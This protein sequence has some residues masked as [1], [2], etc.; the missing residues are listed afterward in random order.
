[1]NGERLEPNERERRYRHAV[2]RLNQAIHNPEYERLAK[3]TNLLTPNQ[4]PSDVVQDDTYT[5][6]VDAM[7]WPTEAEQ[8]T[9]EPRYPF[10]SDEEFAAALIRSPFETTE[11]GERP[12]VLNNF[13]QRLATRQSTF[14]IPEEDAQQQRTGRWQA[15]EAM[16]DTYK[17]EP[18]VYRTNYV[19]PDLMEGLRFL[20]NNTPEGTIDDF[21]DNWTALTKAI[22]QGQDGPAFVRGAHLAYRLMGRLVKPT[23]KQN[24]GGIM[25]GIPP[26]GLPLVTNIHDQLIS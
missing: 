23:D 19:A 24:Q 18:V 15:P 11:S 21:D 12:V 16:F 3:P 25:F 6:L 8:G 14:L 13:I 4:L 2:E 26:S 5:D 7:G 10:V 22:L 1:M 9:M 17:V 20:L